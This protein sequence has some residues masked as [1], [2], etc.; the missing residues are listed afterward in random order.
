M[1]TYV[2]PP[3]LGDEINELLKSAGYE[4]IYFK[5]NQF[6]KITDGLLDQLITKLEYMGKHEK[7]LI[8]EEQIRKLKQI[9]KI[10]KPTLPKSTEISKLA[11]KENISEDSETKIQISKLKSKKK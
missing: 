3:Q 6:V 8:L 2:V 7:N 5:T 10:E 11:D 4:G 1:I 9:I